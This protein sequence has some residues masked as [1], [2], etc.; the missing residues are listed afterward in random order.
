MDR[1]TVSS[2][3]SRHHPRWRQDLGM[4]RRDPRHWLPWPSGWDCSPERRVRL[5]P[6]FQ[7]I[8]K[9]SLRWFQLRLR[10]RRAPHSCQACYSASA[11]QFFRAHPCPPSFVAYV[12]L[13]MFPPASGLPPPASRLQPPASASGLPP[14]ASS[15]RPAASR[16][17]SPACG[18]QPPASFTWKV[19]PTALESSSGEESCGSHDVTCATRPASTL[20]PSHFHWSAEDAS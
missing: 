2:C 17:P 19:L 4:P 11:P 10:P 9:S 12:P 14:P 8:G 3:H 1:L 20:S 18:L 5:S 13:L 6:C 7:L 15:H 16:L